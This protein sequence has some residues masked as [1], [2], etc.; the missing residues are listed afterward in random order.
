MFN[1]LKLSY[2]IF[3]KFGMD[4]AKKNAGAL[5][6]EPGMVGQGQFEL[7]RGEYKNFPCSLEQEIFENQKSLGCLFKQQKL[8][9]IWISTTF[10]PKIIFQDGFLNDAVA[11]GK[12]WLKRQIKRWNKAGIFLIIGEFSAVRLP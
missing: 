9:I 1:S 4:R 7:G 6:T 3:A 11:S 12:L 5:L 8:S 2:Q 10:A